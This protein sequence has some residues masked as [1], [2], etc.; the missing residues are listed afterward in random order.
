[1][2]SDYNIFIEQKWLHNALRI[3]GHDREFQSDLWHVAAN[4]DLVAGVPMEWDLVLRWSHKSSNPGHVLVGS[5]PL[6]ATENARRNGAQKSLVAALRAELDQIL[7]T[8]RVKSDR[9]EV[10]TRAICKALGLSNLACQILSYVVRFNL[11]RV[12]PWV[13]CEI[14]DRDH[15][16]FQELMA[17]A[18]GQSQ[19]DVRQI[20]SPQGELAESGL[21]ADRSDFLLRYDDKTRISLS[22]TALQLILGARIFPQDVYVSICGQKTR[23][24]LN[25]KDFEHLD[26]DRTTIER[27][28]IAAAPRKQPGVNILLY[29]PPGT[30]KTEF[31]KA[32]AE[33]IGFG[34]YLVGEGLAKDEEP[35]RAERLRNL[36]QCQRILR[37]SQQSVLIFDEMEDVACKH[38]DFGTK[39]S[40]V[41]LNRLTEKNPIPII[42][43]SNDISSFDRALV[44]RMTI[45]AHI[46]PPPRKVRRQVLDR[47]LI[48]HNLDLLEVDRERLSARVGLPPALLENAVRVGHLCEG[49]A[50][51]I[52]RVLTTHADL[53]LGLSS[54]C[55][56]EKRKVE[57]NP[58]LI[59]SPTNLH[60]IVQHLKTTPN[61]RQVSF[62]LFGPPGTG[63]TEF[64]HQLAQALDQELHLVRGS[65]LL[66][67]YVGGTEKN[68]AAAF[69][70]ARQDNALLLVDEADTFLYSRQSNARSWEN[71]Q[72]NEMLTAMEAHPLPFVMTTN[73]LDALDPAALRRFTFRAEFC[74]LSPEQISIAFEFFFGRSAPAFLRQSECLTPADFDLVRRRISRL[75]PINPLEIALMLKEECES[76]PA[77]RRPI[78]FS[79]GPGNAV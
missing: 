25:W 65:D 35:S 41:Y 61:E 75:P 77:F 24:A 13:L 74:Y 57:V 10:N 34:A 17:A 4:E 51:T 70:A 72:V 60:A 21:I 30:G 39:S 53:V 46:K 32:I 7:K 44:R 11:K 40:K 1:M 18:L 67:M 29:G 37:N 3:L 14:Y 27:V 55:Q 68:I 47:M 50:S 31:A 20:L 43:I 73:R 62:C 2:I 33:R 28:L 48:T 15:H 66:S 36:Q 49:D 69:E 56:P 23:T 71:S 8:C 52:S 64:G 76:K 54:P 6:I 22:E 5:Q 78:G 12:Q 58:Q 79:G 19:E 9:I 26:P 16:T 63:K 38:T 45:I 59:N 42:W